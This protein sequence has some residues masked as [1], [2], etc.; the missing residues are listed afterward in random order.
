MSDSIN[1]EESKPKC[2]CGC[3]ESVKWNRSKKTWNTYIQGHHNKIMWENPEYRANKAKQMKAMWE[4]PERRDN[5]SKQSKAMWENGDYRANI[6]KQ[7]K[8]LWENP[9]HREAMQVMRMNPEYRETKSK[10]MQALWE[11]PEYRANKTKQAKAQFQ[12]P[13]YIANKAKQAKAQWENTDYRENHSKHSKAMWKK[14]DYIAKVFAGWRKAPNIPEKLLSQLT[15]DN[16]IF[17]GNGKFWRTL[18]LKLEDGQI[19]I[20]HK[21]PDF[22]CEKKR[23]ILEFNGDYFHKNDF[24]DDVYIKAWKD[25]GYDLLIIHEFE[26]KVDINKVLNKIANFVGE[27]SWQ[28]SLNI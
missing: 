8:A 25:I 20:K 6:S 16:I 23:K 3:N 24:P 15:S 27:Q 17:V 26:L 14:P 10:Q 28:M 21:N 9:N 7:M 18:K 12:N 2:K 5:M 13:E 11:N 19:V 1:S 4:N 22:V